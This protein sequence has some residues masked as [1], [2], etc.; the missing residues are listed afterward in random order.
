MHLGRWREELVDWSALYLYIVLCAQDRSGD[1][2]AKIAN[3]SKISVHGGTNMTWANPA[4]ARN[5]FDLVVYL[6]QA[7]PNGK[8]TQGNV[9]L[10]LVLVLCVRGSFIRS[11]TRR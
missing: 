11:F 8:L 9:R 3:A 10:V 6:T 5:P 2:R 7:V 1:G 4:E